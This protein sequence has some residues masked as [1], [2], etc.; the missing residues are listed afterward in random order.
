MP[1]RNQETLDSL[2]DALEKNAGDVADACHQIKASTGWLQRWMR[3]DPKVEAA[4]TDAL[5][6]GA[7][8]L[9][10]AM[11]K[12]ATKGWK[13]P[14]FHNGEEVGF[15]RKFSDALLIKA[16]E[17]RKP[18]MYRKAMDVNTS[19]TITNMSDNDLS[20][21]IDSLMSR[22]GMKQLEAPL[23]GEYADFEPILEPEIISIDDIL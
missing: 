22:L 7:Y 17:A 4:I 23:E 15:K 9:E 20:N 8:V 1:V 21:K 14:V 13:E 2:T 10:S 5:V 6:V 16:L 18:D 12:R 3:D 19:V 11:I